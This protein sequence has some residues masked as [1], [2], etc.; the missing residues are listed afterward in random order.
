MTCSKLF[1][2][3]FIRFMYMGCSKNNRIR[4]TFWSYIIENYCEH[5][6]R[7]HQICKLSFFYYSWFWNKQLSKTTT[8]LY[9]AFGRWSS[10]DIILE[11]RYSMTVWRPYITRSPLRIKATFWQ[12]CTIQNLGLFCCCCCLMNLDKA[13]RVSMMSTGAAHQRLLLRFQTSRQKKT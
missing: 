5:T 9:F 3:Y 2:Q 12:E 10:Q 1:L 8:L 13:G 11:S 4:R 7:W 6:A